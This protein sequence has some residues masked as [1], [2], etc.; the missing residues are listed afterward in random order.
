M[1]GA[2]DRRGLVLALDIGGTKFAA[3]VV[4]GSGGVH[5]RTRVPV[6]PGGDAERLFAVLVGCADAA[7]ARAGVE[8]GDVVGVGC[9]SGG[10]MRW[11]AGAISPLNIPGW[12]AF[13]LRDRLLAAFPGRPVLVHN[14]A[15]AIAAGEHWRG[16]ARGVAN[17]IAVTVSTGVGGGLVIAGHLVHGVSGNAGHIGHA[18]VDPGGPACVCGGRGCLEAI[19]SG[20]NSVRWAVDQGWRPAG[21]EVGNGEVLARAARAGDEVA[22]RALSRAGDALGVALASCAS[23]LDLEVAVVAGG[24]SQSG[25]LFWDALRAAFKRHA[26]MEFASRMEIRPSENPAEV[27]LQGAAA[28]VHAYEIY[29]WSV[30]GAR[31]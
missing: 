16:T 12:R 28:F 29:G 7:L 18:V 6:P 31:G 24:F 11:P 25:E 27:A 2:A 19:A 5:G 4:D 30:P 10:P 3:G 23:L 20:P 15:V 17:M 8:R 14:D 22:S 13:P 1:V 9:G 26:T 21:G